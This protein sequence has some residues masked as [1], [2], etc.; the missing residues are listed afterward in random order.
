MKQRERETQNTH[1]LPLKKSM[2][3]KKKI[4]PQTNQHKSRN[5]TF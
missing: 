1:P 3:K 4:L 2:Q 5:K